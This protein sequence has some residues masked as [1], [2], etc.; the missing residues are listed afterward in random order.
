MIHTECDNF[1]AGSRKWLICRNEAGLS[2]AKTNAYRKQWGFSPLDEPVIETS[3]PPDAVIPEFIFHGRSVSDEAVGGG[4]KL[5]GPGTELLKIYETA[6]VPTCDA[7]KEL[8][9]DMNNWGIAECR[10]RIDEIVLDIL[11]RAKAWLEAKHPWAMKL[12]PDA[13]EEY[14]I[15]KRIRSDITRAIDESERL[16]EDR[17]SKKLNIVTGEKIKGCSSCGGQ[18]AKSIPKYSVNR[19]VHS[20]L[21]EIPLVGQP[22]NRDRLQS[23]ILYHI[24]PLAGKTEWVWRRHCNWLREVRP[25]FNGRLII[26]IVTKGDG[27]AWEYF[28]PEAVK[29][30]LAGLGAEYVE[31]PNDTGTARR[32]KNVRQGLGE[33]VLFPKMLGMLETSDPDH[34]AFYGHCKGVTRPDSSLS[35]A[36]NLWAVA[37]FEALFRN[38]EAAISALDSYGICGSFRMPGGYRD[39]G[40]GIGSNWFYSGTFF[41]MRLVDVFKRQWAYIPTHYGCVEQWPRLNFDQQTQSA[42]LFFDNVTNLYDESYWKNIVT[43]EFEKWKKNR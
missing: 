32:K 14:A 34:I 43:P 33:G 37:M 3:S 1:P 12:I 35:S 20:K 19:R 42:C 21:A 22:I 4:I 17:R 13:I 18:S 10:K 6:G 30:E 7:C 27:D 23:H 8:A 40:P 2:I 9:Q 15:S 26:G 29:E 25:K 31:A 24:M 41:A 39:G 28:P 36:V 5:Y 11:P 38:Q 16:I